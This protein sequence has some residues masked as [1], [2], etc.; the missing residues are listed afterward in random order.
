MTRILIAND[1]VGSLIWSFSAAPLGVE[2][3]E[4]VSRADAIVAALESE[5]D[6]LLVSG[7]G[8]GCAAAPLVR[9]VRA[10]A[11]ALA[12]IAVPGVGE[13]AAAV[14]HAGADA[15]LRGLGD[16]TN[17][18]A[19]LEQ[20]CAVARNRRALERSR[21]AAEE[22]P[23]MDHA[24]GTANLALA[25]LMLDN[26]LA[27]AARQS[28]A[29][30]VL[31]I[32]ADSLGPLVSSHGPAADTAVDDELRARIRECVRDY[33]V[34]ARVP[35]GG[36]VVVIFPCETAVAEGVASRLSA[37]AAE[38]LMILGGE[39]VRLDCSVGVATLPAGAPRAEVEDILARASD[40]LADAR[41]GGG[42][43]VAFSPTPRVPQVLPLL[44]RKT[45]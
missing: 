38:R 39:R 31:A 21:L 30:S 27:R 25:R 28:E 1:D 11:P 3:A 15:I 6:V 35:G 45:G 8:L 9:S 23:R 16:A 29:L 44:A 5:A 19:V 2:V 17:R 41:L 37:L 14:S 34:V 10:A 43:R 40:A 36:M 24:S 12:I 20:A 33:D 7:V 42:A 22:A 32:E 4:V 13:D 18:Q 26:L